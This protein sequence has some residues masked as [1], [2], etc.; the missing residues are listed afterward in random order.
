MLSMA[1]NIEIWYSQKDRS[2]SHTLL[3]EKLMPEPRTR[4]LPDNNVLVCIGIEYP[5]QA[6]ALERYGTGIVV[7]DITEHGGR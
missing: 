5:G 1:S 4:H 6:R 7:S 2:S 3:K